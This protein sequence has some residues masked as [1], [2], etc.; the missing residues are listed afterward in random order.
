MSKIVSKSFSS[1]CPYLNRV[2]SIDIDYAKIQVLGQAIPGYKSIS[3]SCDFSE[4]CPYPNQD[5][6]GR[7]PVYLAASEKPY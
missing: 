2:H 6:F 3:Y 1:N 5:R 7:C 4:E